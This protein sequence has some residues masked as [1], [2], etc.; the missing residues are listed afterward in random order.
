MTLR[1]FPA[2]EMTG[3]AFGFKIS[4]QAIREDLNS[5]WNKNATSRSNDSLFVEKNEKMRSNVRAFAI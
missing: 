2:A 5:Q 1:D 3:D 4:F